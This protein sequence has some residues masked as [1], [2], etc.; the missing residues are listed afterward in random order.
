[1]NVRLKPSGDKDG[2][3]EGVPSLT[4]GLEESTV[5][6]LKLGGRKSTL[7]KKKSGKSGR[8]V[9]MATEQ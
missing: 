7:K 1:M 3:L 4:P 8:E 9:E 6:W 2:R 5:M